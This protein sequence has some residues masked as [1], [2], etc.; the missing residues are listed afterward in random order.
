MMLAYCNA[1]KTCYRLEFCSLR[2]LAKRTR[3]VINLPVH[4]YAW[5]NAMINAAIVGHG[6]L[7]IVSTKKPHLHMSV[8]FQ[9]IA[10]EM[11][12]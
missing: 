1:K 6:S 9:S 3:K 2:K 5:Q 4:W 10:F 12:R 8:K 11:K 7:R